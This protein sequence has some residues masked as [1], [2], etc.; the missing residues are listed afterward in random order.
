MRHGGQAVPEDEGEGQAVI[1]TIS[2]EDVRDILSMGR[3]MADLAGKAGRDKQNPGLSRV[4]ATV[5]AVNDDG[6]LT[7]NL[8]S[9]S[10]PILRTYKMTSACY[11]AKVGDRVIVDTLNHISYITGILAR[12][13][14]HYVV[15]IETQ[16]IEAGVV[17]CA[18]SSGVAIVAAS[19]Q[20]S[21]Q[22]AGWGELVIAAGLP[23]TVDGGSWYSGQVVW[24]TQNKY[25]SFAYVNGDGELRI[26]L[27]QSAA[28]ISGQWC[29]F[30]L[31]YPVA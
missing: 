9:A 6:K 18:V 27:K 3:D 30:G 25:N 1:E 19:M 2:N 7:V 4:E 15:P 5:S 29:F 28:L 31:S 12:D 21:A 8:G 16:N 22:I 24:Q 26:F 20:T 11:G 23:P 17:K 13:N 10:K 14:G